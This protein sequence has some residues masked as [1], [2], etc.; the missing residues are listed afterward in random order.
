MTDRRTGAAAAASGNSRALFAERFALLYVTAGDPPL[1]RVADTVERARR[2]DERGRP[3]RAGAQRISDWRR[4]RNVPARFA[5]LAVVLEVLIGE[6]RKQRPHPPVDGLYDVAAWRRLWE[7]ALRTPISTAEPAEAEQ[8]EEQ[9]EDSG[10]C[11]YRGLAAF[12]QEDSA[13]FF[14]REA[15]TGTLV[16]RLGSAAEDGGITMLVGASGAG[17]SSLLRAGLA[18]A[19]AE[20][21]V[22]GS[23][24]WPVLTTTPGEDP[25]K[26]LIALVPELNEVLG[27]V[28]SVPDEPGAEFGFAEAVRDAV[29]ARARAQ[30][31]DDRA[32]LVLVVDQFEETFT[33]CR[34]E[35]TRALFVQVLHAMCTTGFAAGDAPG[36][37]VLGLRADFYGRCLDYPELSEALQRRQMVLGAM[38]TAELRKAITG[39]ARATGLQIEPGLVDVLLR[40]LGVGV[41]RAYG[42]PGQRAYDAGALP[43]L[44]H[45]LLATWQRRQAGRLTIAGYRAAGGIQGAVAGTAERAWAE[46]DERGQAAARTV[47]LRLV[48]VGEDT[49]DTRRR[50][51]RQEIVDHSED[52]ESTERALDVLAG[53]RLVTLDADAVEI[54]HEAL[55]YAWPRL[56]GW[57]DQ[58]RAGN[59]ARQRLERDAETWAAEGRDPSLLYRGAR[60]ETARHWA[61]QVSSA[62]L[63]SVS[64][65]FLTAS[66][67]HRRR[68][69]WLRRSGVAAVCVLAVI[70]V[71]AALVAVHEKDDAQF[72]QVLAQADRLQNTDP[73]AAA[74]LNLVADELR[75]HDGGVLTRLLSTQNAPLS[76][77]MTGHQGSVYLTTFSPDG[78][79]LAT[80]GYDN[81]VRLWDVR[82]RGRP[83][84]LGA[85]ITGFGSWVTSAV[86][87]PDGRTLAAAG[88][89]KQ[90]RL[91]D[92]RD[93]LHP[94]LLLP[95]ISGGDG[96]IYLLAFSPDGRT[97]AT[98]N[99]NRT[100]RLWNVADPAHPVSLATLTGH[101][102]QVRTLDF[103]PDGRTLATGGDD[104]TA[105]LWNVADPAH[106][107][108]AGPPLVG[109]TE[110]LHSVAF[111]PD[112]TKLASGSVDKTVRLWDV[113]DPAR[114]EQLGSALTG[115]RGPVWSVKFSPDGRTLA[116]SSKD[117]TAK[118]WSVADPRNASQLGQDL[119]AGSSTVFAVGFS[120]D[121][122]T[123]ATG[124][125][126][127]MV[128]LWSLPN[129]ILAGHTAAVSEAAF[130]PDGRSVV[131][132]GEDRRLQVWDTTDPLHPAA[133][134]PPLPVY[135]GPVGS[136]YAEA[137]RPDGKVLAT[138]GGAGLVRLWDFS[139]RD[140]PRPL[141]EPLPVATRYSGEVAFSHDG[142]LLAT[143][144][145]DL[146][147]QLWDVRDPAHPVRLGGPAVQHGG[148][149]SQVAFN[150]DATVLASASSD[151]TARLWDI[152][153]PA[154]SRPLSP[155][156][157]AHGGAVHAVAFSPDG[158]TMV[159]AGADKTARLWDVRDPRA[160]KQLGEPLRGHS[161]QVIAAAFSADGTRLATGS[162]DRTARLWDVSDPDHPAPIGQSLAEHDA[163][164]NSVQFSP[165]GRTLVTASGDNTA[166]VWDL[167]VQRSVRR[168]CE[169]TRGVLS[170]QQWEQAIPAIAYRRLCD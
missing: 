61:E 2:Q 91:F 69:G 67:R 106:P 137:F 50:A 168:I 108:P 123:L 16:D 63:S 159:T 131:T 111:S 162:E 85:P 77:P 96:T 100:A 74:R 117:S 120:P 54:S 158:T 104:R 33:M 127:G 15:S 46:L 72:R 37:V 20:G 75:P 47:L 53:A 102:A 109:H 152:R 130:S 88:D 49:K 110:G 97:L 10:V 11:P 149:V 133:A 95:P 169:S 78:T 42:K 135:D 125:D 170:P 92:V 5:A 139:D 13:W 121:G 51:H 155:P 64:Q 18:P 105:R 122:R 89:D 148:Y 114:A 31:G 48:H 112:G 87:S 65:E 124:S 30:A 141:G 58:D 36:L 167:D 136:V 99:E 35:L 116:S 8:A 7:E 23:A 154:H 79:K 161:Q 83:K 60:L 101:T 43:L 38:T 56:R 115:H 1:K 25:L 144:N 55:L 84:P 128:R 93:P 32:R 57:I 86:W 9:P 160:P 28:E 24:G 73:S 146:S 21:A 98:A 156:L 71:V 52:R 142:R 118:L 70:A 147:A 94:R 22:P 59:L 90:L 165:D 26:A 27:G 19:L 166:H 44:S 40:D 12:Q 153:D 82:D 126:D 103:S 3:V 41:G 14:G 29:A 143:G 17:K 4:G 39:P 34:D 66:A 150:P 163:S 151:G 129:R 145:D 134:G 68:A 45:A 76:T 107:S 119:A 164:V 132:V 80:A 62:Q 140:H 113:R 81:T 138:G 157:T 6:A